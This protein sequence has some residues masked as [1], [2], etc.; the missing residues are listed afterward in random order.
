[1]TE[2]TKFFNL[3]FPS[4]ATERIARLVEFGFVNCHNSKKDRRKVEVTLSES[5]K[6]LYEHFLKVDLSRLILQCD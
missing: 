3:K 5:G 1:M 6:R 4:T 2:I